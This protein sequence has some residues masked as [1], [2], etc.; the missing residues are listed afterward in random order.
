MAYDL[1]LADRLKKAVKELP[2]TEMKMFGGMAFL[3]NGNM[4]VGI[5][6]DNL[7]ARVGPGKDKTSLSKPHTKPFD[8]TGHPMSGW[9]EVLPAGCKSDQD[10]KNWVNISLEFVTTLPKK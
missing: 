7:I 2:V 8:M 6:G 3:L 9:V 1:V 10:L 4:L 5:H